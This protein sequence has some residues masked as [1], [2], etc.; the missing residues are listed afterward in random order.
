MA[1]ALCEDLLFWVDL[2]VLKA[3]LWLIKWHKMLSEILSCEVPP[4]LNR[5]YHG[6]E[7]DILRADPGPSRSVG[8]GG[9]ESQNLKVSAQTIGDGIMRRRWRRSFSKVVK[10]IPKSIPPHAQHFEVPIY[11]VQN[12]CK[13]LFLVAG[14]RVRG[15]AR[16]SEL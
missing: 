5:E 14:P 4:A 6:A 7:E 13:R 2:A 12:P 9:T 8:K 3:A 16:I 10:C 15:A 11:H 1:P